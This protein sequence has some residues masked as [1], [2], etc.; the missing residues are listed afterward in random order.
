VIAAGLRGAFM[1]ARGHANGLSL[2]EDTPAGAA[3]SFWA[4]ALCLPGFLAL[5]LFAWGMEG[6]PT[7]G[8]GPAL[9]AELLGY[10]CAWAGFALASLS[11]ARAMGQGAA[12]PHFIAAWNWASVVQYLVWLALSLPIVPALPPLVAQGVVLVSLGYA[13]WLEWF[14]ARSALRIAG[15]R[16]LGFVLLDLAIGILIGTLVERLSGG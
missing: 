14:V 12:W 13:L 16:A 1:L 4:A 8:L 7:A 15:N 2:I 6:A 9:A 3:R 5:R 10:A 11:L